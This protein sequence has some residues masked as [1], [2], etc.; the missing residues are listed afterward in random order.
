LMDVPDAKP[1]TKPVTKPDA[2][3]AD[4]AKVAA[5]KT[6]IAEIEQERDAALAVESDMRK[7]FEDG[8]RVIAEAK[9]ILAA[10]AIMPADVFK[11]VLHS[12]HPDRTTDPKQ[13]A[14]Y[15][16]AFRFL[17]DHERML[18]KKPPKPLP[19]RGA[20][21]PD[22]WE[23]WVERKWQGKEERK[24]KAAATRAAKKAAKNPK[25]LCRDDR[26]QR[27]YGP[28]RVKRGGAATRTSRWRDRWCVGRGWETPLDRRALFDHLVGAA[29]ER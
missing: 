8:H 6:R 14:R 28:E 22:T 15:E 12:A 10:K 25:S 2:T 1:V 4:A 17:K 11:T 27:G 26:V 9:A 23:G 21:L 16:N 3:D 19:P 5:L 29:K 13:K 24:A 7:K 18:A 20:D